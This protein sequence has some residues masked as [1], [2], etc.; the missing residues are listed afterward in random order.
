[1][2]FTFPLLA[3]IPSVLSHGLITSPPSRPIGPAILANCGPKV[4]QDIRLDN[5]SHVESR[6][7]LAAKDSVYNAE[8]CNLWLCTG[9]QFPD[10]AN[11]TQTWSAGQVVPVK[12]WIRI[13]HEGSANVSIVDTK[14]NTIVG[15]M[16]KVW[17][18]GYAPGKKESDV[19]EDQ[20]EFN[21]TI[22]AG[23]EDKC[24]KP[25]DCVS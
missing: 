5:T 23:L 15:D 21:V 24:A 14:S 19:P 7:E 8:K 10:N 16:L 17:S 22:P 4:T 6:P 12:I 25:G 13:P 11:N 3:L 2:H 18:S 9:L 20:K 1:M